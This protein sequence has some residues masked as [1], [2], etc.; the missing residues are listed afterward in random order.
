MSSV[1]L[2]LIALTF[3]NFYENGDFFSFLI[4]AP[5]FSNN[6]KD[7]HSKLRAL[8]NFNPLTRSLICSTTTLLLAIPDDAD[9]LVLQ[10]NFGP[11]RNAHDNS[12]TRR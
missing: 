9:V 6:K 2:L 10:Y 1:T 12:I 5:N 11:Y 7:L 3:V 8:D 4:N